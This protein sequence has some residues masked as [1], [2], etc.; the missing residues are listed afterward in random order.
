MGLDITWARRAVLTELSPEQY[1]EAWTPDCSLVHA[2]PNTETAE[3]AE[4]AN[5]IVE[6]IYRCLEVGHFKAGSYGGYN[7]W[8]ETLCRIAIGTSPKEVWARP[9]AYRD[10]SLYELIDFSDCEGVIGAKTCAKLAVDLAE[11]EAHRDEI[12][13][14]GGWLKAFQKAADHGFLVFH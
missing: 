10:Q 3:H 7:E 11:L 5:G 1:D 8:R 2:Y 13:N 9:D 14:Y 12:W 6:G 4:R